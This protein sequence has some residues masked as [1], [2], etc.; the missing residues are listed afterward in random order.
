ML[1]KIIIGFLA[2][3]FLVGKFMDGYDPKYWEVRKIRKEL[4]KQNKNN[5]D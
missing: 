3:C 2:I 5:G 4:Q 1:I